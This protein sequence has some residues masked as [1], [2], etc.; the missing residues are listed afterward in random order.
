[1][2]ISSHIEAGH[3]FLQKEQEAP[4]ERVTSQQQEI[5]RLRRDNSYFE[6]RLEKSEA[7]RR[8]LQRELDQ[9]NEYMKAD[10]TYRIDVDRASSAQYY[11]RSN[12]PINI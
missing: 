2:N 12:Q 9:K 3:T 10:F 11:G 5:E 7:R 6:L 4:P 8:E 1:M